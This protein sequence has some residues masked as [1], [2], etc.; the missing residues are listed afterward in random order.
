MVSGPFPNVGASRR[1]LLAAAPAAG[2]LV[3]GAIDYRSGFEY[4]VF[5]LYFLPLSLAAWYFGLAGALAAALASTFSWLISNYLAGLRFSHPSVLMVNFVMQAVAFAVV[6]TLLAR[7][8]SAVDRESRLS[9]TDPLTGLLNTRAFYQ[10]AER[11]LALARRYGHS[12]TLAYVDLDDFKA[13]NDTFGHRGGDEVLRRVADVL[14]RGV[15]AGDLSARV[16]GDEFAVMLV[17]TGSEGAAAM[18]ERLRCEI[19]AGFSATAQPVTASIGAVS[20]SK[21]PLEVE[22][23]VHRAD[24]IM[25]G[26]KATGK[27]QVRVEF[28]DRRAEAV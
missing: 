8:K 5:P 23:L 10:D 11:L 3:I 17:E 21:P 26:V 28:D 13:V 25:F 24:T 1:W 7:L 4:R 22:P 15:R 16:G 6:G 14:R 2:I 19:A 9:R 27:N 18:L 20:L 12:V